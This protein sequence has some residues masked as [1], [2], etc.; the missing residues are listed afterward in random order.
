MKPAPT[1]AI[2]QSNGS[3]YLY[4]AGGNYQTSVRAHCGNATSA[5][6]NGNYLTI[7]TEKHTVI[8]EY[9]GSGFT[10]RSTKNH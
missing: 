4:T 6:M 1:T 8:H 3:V 9:T 10:Y 7:H 2:V 5:Q